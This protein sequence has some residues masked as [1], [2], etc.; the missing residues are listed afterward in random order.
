MRLTLPTILVLLSA[1]EPMVTHRGHIQQETMLEQVKPGTDKAELRRRFGSPSAMS[2][3][4]AE[5]WY[6]I[7]TRKEAKGFLKPDITEQQVLAVTFDE[8]GQVE[9]VDNYDEADAMPVVSVK[10][11]T[12]TEGHSIG[13]FEQ[14][15]GNLGRFNTGDRQVNPR[16]PGF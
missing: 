5:T 6:Y 12:P 11:T 13:F 10:K 9:S 8:L 7:Q 1:C 14:V 4:G 16:G 2:Q 3:F 15:L